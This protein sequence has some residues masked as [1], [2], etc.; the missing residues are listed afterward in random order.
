MFITIDLLV[1][2][3]QVWD[4]ISPLRPIGESWRRL[5]TKNVG[6]AMVRGMSK[7]Y[8]RINGAYVSKEETSAK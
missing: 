7:T 4:V 1:K 8:P 5:L 2:E 6:P 3:T